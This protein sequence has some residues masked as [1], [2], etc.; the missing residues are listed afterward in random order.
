[1]SRIAI[2]RSQLQ[3]HAGAQ[4]LGGSQSGAQTQPTWGCFRLETSKLASRREVREGNRH[5]WQLNKHSL[6][7]SDR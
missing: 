3:T 5:L 7:K 4:L 6:F 1:M 2:A